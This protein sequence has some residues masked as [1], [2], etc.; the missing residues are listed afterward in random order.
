MLK[1]SECMEK[2]FLK[3]HVQLYKSNDD[4]GFCL[5]RDLLNSYG[6]ESLD[7]IIK[8]IKS[9]KRLHENSL[10]QK[11]AFEQT[12]EILKTLCSIYRMIP[13][14]TFDKNVNYL[15]KMLFK[16]YEDQISLNGFLNVSE[17]WYDYLF[18]KNIEDGDY[19][20]SVRESHDRVQKAYKGKGYSK[21]ILTMFPASVK[22]YEGLAYNDDEYQ[23]KIPK[24]PEEMEEVGSKLKICVG[25]YA[26]A[27]AKQNTQVLWLCKENKEIMALEVKKGRLIQAKAENNHFPNA[28]EEAFI[29]KWCKEK[30]IDIISY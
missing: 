18:M 25:T 13:G 6:R 16:N 29:K 21:E 3:G 17:M 20:N 19:P 22:E 27:V 15:L 1:L 5:F 2:E 30:M 11:K 26:P 9:M 12:S 4:Y 23:I 14:S 8:F 28:K 10:F 24:S 7:S